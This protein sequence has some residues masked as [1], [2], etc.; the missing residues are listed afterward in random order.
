MCS[1]AA[2]RHANRQRRQ[3]Q[4]QAGIVH[5]LHLLGMATRAK[6][7]STDTRAVRVLRRKRSPRMRPLPVYCVDIWSGDVV[8]ATAVVA[9]A[10]VSIY[11]NEP[12]LRSDLGGRNTLVVMLPVELPRCTSMS[13]Q[14]RP[15][16]DVSL[17]YPC[18]AY[19][20]LRVA[21]LREDDEPCIE[22]PDGMQLVAGR[23]LPARAIVRIQLQYDALIDKQLRERLRTDTRV[24]VCGASVPTKK[25]VKD[26]KAL[27]YATALK[28]DTAN[29]D[30]DES[31][32]Y[33]PLDVVEQVL[34]YV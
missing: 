5:Q 32:E 7:G 12:Y 16:T 25:Q 34:R 10:R 4:I 20:D 29:H 11:T 13:V 14:T 28:A 8:T 18:D 17:T 33:M 24:Y 3:W 23:L 15:I 30:A 19:C 27:V 2:A 26:T 31:I 21:V 22:V 6:R 1:C 9:Y